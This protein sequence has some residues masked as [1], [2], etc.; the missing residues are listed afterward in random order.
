MARAAAWLC[1]AL[2]LVSAPAL[3]R[4][5]QA[6]AQAEVAA[7]AP[8]GAS[9]DL[10]AVGEHALHACSVDA[11][12]AATDP[13]APLAGRSEPRIAA[14]AQTATARTPGTLGAGRL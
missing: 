8:I 10:D 9:A 4:A 3:V 12:G 6:A 1:I 2:T 11:D 5:Q 13:T 7:V 14:A